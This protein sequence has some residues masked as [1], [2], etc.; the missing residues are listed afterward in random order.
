MEA[1]LHCVNRPTPDECA[2]AFDAEIAGRASIAFSA[3]CRLAV[4]AESCAAGCCRAYE[5]VVLSPGERAPRGWTIYE[6]R[7]GRAIG[8]TA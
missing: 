8:R 1:V 4:H 3:G 5:F 2:A 7:D 6:E